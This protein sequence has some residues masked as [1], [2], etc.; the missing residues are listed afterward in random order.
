METAVQP[1]RPAIR[2]SKPYGTSSWNNTV[3]RKP[4]FNVTS[5]WHL[6]VS[7]KNFNELLAIHTWPVCGKSHFRTIFFGHQV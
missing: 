4:Q 5:F 1:P 7:P 2:T 3:Q 6:L